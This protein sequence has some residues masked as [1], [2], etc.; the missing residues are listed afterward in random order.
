MIDNLNK[1]IANRE[2]S[3]NLQTKHL[4]ILQSM[5]MILYMAPRPLKRFLQKHVETLAGRMI[6][7]D[8]VRAGDVI[9]IDSDGNGLT[10]SIRKNAQA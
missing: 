3:L 9:L 1:R 10:A 4:L 2:L 6:L 8:E 5:A 7:G